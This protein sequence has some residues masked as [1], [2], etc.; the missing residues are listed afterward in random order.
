[1]SN[2]FEYR[3]KI[4]SMKLTRSLSKFEGYE[5]KKFVPKIQSKNSFFMSDYKNKMNNDMIGV[6][7]DK[8][9]KN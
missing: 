3:E 2:T 8:K 4:E 1:M 5:T 7:L 6:F 9:I